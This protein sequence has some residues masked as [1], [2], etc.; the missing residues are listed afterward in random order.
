LAKAAHFRVDP[1]LASALGQGYRSS[2][3]A[4]RE[5]FDN[6]WDADAENVSIQL[7]MELSGDAIVIQDD[8]SGMT[9]NELRGEYLV[10]ASD[11]RTRKGQHT[12]GKKRLVKGRKG[13]GKFAGLTAADTMIL[14]TK[15]RGQG[16]TRAGLLRHN[17][18]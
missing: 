1:K 12:A 3:E 9:E 8:G 15:A 11:R 6:A 13:I 18:D 10:V 14:E 5:L 7:P 17:T 2:E 16:H 4:L